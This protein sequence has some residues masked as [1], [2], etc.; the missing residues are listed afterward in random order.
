MKMWIAWSRNDCE[1]NC[2]VYRWKCELLDLEMKMWI[3]W[4]TEDLVN[5]LGQKLPGPEIALG[6]AWARNCLVVN[7]LAQSWA[8]HEKLGLAEVG[9]S[10]NCLLLVF[11]HCMLGCSGRAGVNDSLCPPVTL[12]L[13]LCQHFMISCVFDW[14]L[15]CFFNLFCWQQQRTFSLKLFHYRCIRVFTY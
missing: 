4:C 5:C 11:V 8:T 10:G 13:F 1:A 12:R 14:F 15:F 2:L 6:I 7:C 3:A 9:Q